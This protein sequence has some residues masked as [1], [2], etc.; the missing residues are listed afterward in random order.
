MLELSYSERMQIVEDIVDKY[1]NL[2]YKAETD[3]FT[4]PLYYAKF[5]YKDNVMTICQFISAYNEHLI[6]RL[7]SDK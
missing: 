4:C 1:R 7:T 2:C 3:C 6:E 5:A